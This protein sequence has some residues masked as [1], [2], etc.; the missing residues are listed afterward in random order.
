[1]LTCPDLNSALEQAGR[2]VWENGAKQKWDCDYQAK[3]EVFIGWVH[4]FIFM[5]GS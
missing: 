2:T 4:S 3:F 1:M 5:S